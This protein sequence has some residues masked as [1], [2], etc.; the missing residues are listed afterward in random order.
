MTLDF[1]FLAGGPS[2]YRL[3]SLSPSFSQCKWGK[4]VN[5]KLVSYGLNMTLDV[6][7]LTCHKL[8]TWRL[9]IVSCCNFMLLEILLTA[10]S[11]GS[12]VQAPNTAVYSSIA[13]GP[14]WAACVSVKEFEGCPGRSGGGA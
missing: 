9:L 14:R 6:N 10:V 12:P 4:N 8:V 7:Q 2:L 11:S 5:L 13:L 1:G 3:T